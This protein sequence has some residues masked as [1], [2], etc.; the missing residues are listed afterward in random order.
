[1]DSPLEL[2]A[3]APGGGRAA[4]VLSWDGLAATV[5][6]N[7]VGGWQVTVPSSGGAAERRALVE[8]ARPG[9]GLIVTR[10]MLV[11]GERREPV[12]F[13]GPVE[14]ITITSQ[15]VALIE[16][17]DDNVYMFGR[18]ASPEPGTPSPPFSAQSHDVR[19][20]VA[21]TLMLAYVDDNGGS[22]ALPERRIPGL[23]LQADPIVGATITGRARWQTLADLLAE[24]GRV[25][26]VAW[27]V[28]DL[29]LEVFQPSPVPVIVSE[30]RGNLAGWE[31]VS[32]APEANVVVV[33]GQGTGAARTILIGQDAAS[34]AT[35]GRWETFQ[36][37]RDTDSTAELASAA[38]STLADSIPVPTVAASVIERPGS[39]WGADWDL[40]SRLTVEV[41]GLRITDTVAE[42]Q[43]EATVDSVDISILVGSETSS[44][45]ITGA[46]RALS[47]L[48]RRTSAMER[49]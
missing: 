10:P 42:V 44:P 36:D 26:R 14:R 20:G 5:R 45:R 12:L 41:D 8:L 37:R 13:S 33:A 47:D 27:R 23:A 32:A 16:G 48:S 40:G 21:S 35:W 15:G 7:G 22:G 9:A 17:H 3:R 29:T 39:M 19:T 49:I 24:L 11:A 38:A 2:W 25:G 6:R 31:Y 4:A 46:L 34:V 1:M 18:L 30:D 43:V 28:R